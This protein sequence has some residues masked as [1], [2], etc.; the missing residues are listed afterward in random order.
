MFL[1]IIVPVYNIEKY[2][3]RCLDS[4]LKAPIDDYEIILVTGNSSDNSNRIC[5]NYQTNYPNIKVIQ[6]SGTGLS[7]A[8]NCAFDIASGKYVSY[9]DGDDYIDSEL[10][11]ELIK[12]LKTQQEDIDFVVTDFKYI[13]TGNEKVEKV[14]Q[15]GKNSVP[16]DSMDYLPR[17]LRKRRSFWNV[18]RYIYRKAFLVEH[19]IRFL[20]NKLSEDVDYTTKVLLSAKRPLFVHCPFYYYTVGRGDSLLDRTTYKHIQDAVDILSNSIRMVQRSSFMYAQLLI[21]QYQFEYVLI[22]V[23]LYDL[24]KDERKRARL[25]FDSTLDILNIGSDK[26]SHFI[27]VIL[28]IVPVM[29]FAA[30]LYV[31]KLCRQF[32]KRGTIKVRGVK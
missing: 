20:E 2:V 24:A 12:T 25:L 18:W 7:N 21:A 22:T 9:I 28:Y 23:H 26:L 32:V 11:G 16:R 15:I 19:G 13:N 30:I 17:M 27:R 8:R 6:Q 4:I 3:A 5:E 14:Y 1:S 10:Y 31:L 29:F